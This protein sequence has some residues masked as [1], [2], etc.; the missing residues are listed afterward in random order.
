M[1]EE[2]GKSKLNRKQPKTS[3]QEKIKQKEKRQKNGIC[4]LLRQ[5]SAY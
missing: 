1:D 4:P 5:S 2:R 3:E